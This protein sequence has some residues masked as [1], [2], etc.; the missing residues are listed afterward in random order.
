MVHSWRVLSP[1]QAAPANDNLMNRN[2]ASGSR[3]QPRVIQIPVDIR[4]RPASV[5][6]MAKKT[7]LPACCV[8]VE[9]SCR[10]YRPNPCP[11]TSRGISSS[12]Y[13]CEGIFE[14]LGRLAPLGEAPSSQGP[15]SLNDRVDSDSS[16]V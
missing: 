2:T 4:S 8:V 13:L 3:P 10:K 15:K 5:A 7:Q 9:V 12:G 14:A 16:R 11:E 6:A 1:R